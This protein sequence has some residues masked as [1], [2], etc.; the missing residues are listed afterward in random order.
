[1]KSLTIKETQYKHIEMWNWIAEQSEKKKSSVGKTEY[2]NA[3]GIKEKPVYY[4]WCCEFVNGVQ[5]LIGIS[6]NGLE[7]KL[8]PVKDWEEKNSGSLYPPCVRGLYGTWLKSI[9]GFDYK[10]ASK[11]AKK[12]ANLQFVERLNITAEQEKSLI[13]AG[14]GDIFILK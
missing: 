7:C 10:K 6:P 1:M 11:I 3:I 4:C 12:I 8:C 9:N 14:L 5:N 2:F 13:D